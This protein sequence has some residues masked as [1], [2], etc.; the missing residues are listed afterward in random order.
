[1]DVA[2]HK[3]AVLKACLQPWINEAYTITKSIEAKLAQLQENQERI[4]GSSST[5][6]VTEQHVEEVQQAAT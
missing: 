3:E 4:Q 2:R 6:M 1:V 5:T